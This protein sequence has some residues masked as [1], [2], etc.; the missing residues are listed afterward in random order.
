MTGKMLI[1]PRRIAR[2]IWHARSFYLF[3][4]PSLIAFFLFSLIPLV[5]VVVLSFQS[6]QLVGAP[7]RFVGLANYLSV[8]ADVDFQKALLNT[9]KYVLLGNPTVM[10][11]SL[12]LAL[13]LNQ[14]LRFRGLI[15]A[16]L[17]IP[18]LVPMTIVAGIWQ[19]V[20]YPQGGALNWLIG[21]V[22][23]RPQL[24]LGNPGL[25]LPTL[26]MIDAWRGIGFY[27]IIWYAALKAI[28]ADLYE[29]AALDGAGTFQKLRYITLPLLRPTTVVLV[30]L[31]VIWGSQAFDSIFVLTT[32]GPLQSTMTAVYYI[33]T[34]TFQGGDVGYASTMSVVLC[35]L[36]FAISIVMYR[37]LRSQFEY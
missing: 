32:G 12:G 19:F 36:V 26:V 28:P 27:A 35:L 5:Y 14:R 22:G 30:V 33:Y 11:V 2:E 9:I 10:I 3:L 21:L 20:L 13:I 25:A 4:A 16:T 6:G 1:G 15:Q 24:W 34:Q 17:F 37:A 18:Y 8:F 31:S 29:V 23:I 7:L